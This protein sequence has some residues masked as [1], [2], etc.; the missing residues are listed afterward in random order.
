MND[1]MMQQYHVEHQ[2]I[3]HHLKETVSKDS[4]KDVDV[5]VALFRG[6]CSIGLALS[7]LLKKPLHICFAPSKYDVAI[8]EN[9][10]DISIHPILPDY[11]KILL[12]DDIS[13]TGITL[14]AVLKF[15]EEKGNTD[16]IT[17][18]SVIKVSTQYT[19]HYYGIVIPDKYWVVFPW[20]V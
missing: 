4:F 2:L 3:Q 20:E 12:V 16:I 11:C 15:L 14:Q 7:H 6:G 1:Q 10:C 9:I 17:Y 13:D 19:P 18:T 8:N 5:V